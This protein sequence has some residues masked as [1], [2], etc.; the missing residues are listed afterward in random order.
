MF[1]EIESLKPEPLHVHHVFQAGELTFSREDA[2]LKEPVTADFVLEHTGSDLHISGSVNT[3]VRFQ[4]ARCTKE[5]VK[6]LSAGFDLSYLP[7]PEWTDEE[8]EVELHYEDMEVAFYDGIAL[9]VDQMVL[10]QIELALPMRFVCREDCKG[11]CPQC[12]TDLNEGPCSCSKETADARLASLLDF[13][14]KMD[15]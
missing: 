9:D 4:C 2:I 10:E 13:R 15:S 11:L 14:R 1:I 12:G 7:Q 6:D 8:G 5:F 3:T